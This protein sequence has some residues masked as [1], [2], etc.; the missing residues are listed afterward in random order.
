MLYFRKRT[1]N[2][3]LKQTKEESPLPLLG[4]E[5]QFDNGRYKRKKGRKRYSKNKADHSNMTLDNEKTSLMKTNGDLEGASARFAYESAN[6]DASRLYHEK[7]AAGSSDD[8][9][10][11]WHQSAG[12]LLQ[13]V[14]FGGLDGILTSFAIVAGAAGG[15]LSVSAVLVLGFSNIFADALR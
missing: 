8:E 5:I 6:A 9:E 13:P 10:E 7:K 2:Q 3:N 11:P 4:S 12:G 1:I 15:G 14:I